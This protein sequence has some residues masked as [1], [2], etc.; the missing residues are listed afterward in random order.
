MTSKYYEFKT[1]TK[2]FIDNAEKVLSELKGKRVIIYGD[3][4]N[5][6]ELNRRYR[7][8]EKFDIVAFISADENR[9]LS[10]LFGIKNIKQKEVSEEDFDA[11]LITMEHDSEIIL[12]DYKA[13]FGENTDIKCL[14]VEKYLDADF[15]LEYLLKYRFDKT[16]P[17]LV[18]KMKGKK[19]LFYGSGLFF[20]LINQYYDLSGLDAIGV[21][22]KRFSQLDDCDEVCGYKL[23]S[24]EQIVELNPDYVLITT[25]RIIPIADFLYSKYLKNT[26]I[27]I[28]PLV[29]KGFFATIKEG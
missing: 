19:V 21:V 15:N 20:R 14:F 13:E 18:K 2:E 17:K 12:R 3:V 7:F 22:D 8:K 11:I 28:M 23:Y 24:P 5:Y 26:N 1:K 6:A 27:K 4:E 25:K 9:K 29:K 10:R 16:L